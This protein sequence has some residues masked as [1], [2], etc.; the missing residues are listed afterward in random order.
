MNFLNQKPCI[1]SCVVLSKSMCISVLGLSSSPS[2]SLV[3]LFIHSGFSLCFLVAIFSSKIVRFL[4]HPVVGM[5][6]CHSFPVVGRIFFRCFGKSYFVCIVLPFV[7]ISLIF[8]L[9]PALSGLFTQVVLLFFS[10]V[11]CFCFLFPLISAPLFF[12]SFWFVFVVYFICISSGI[13]HPGFDCFFVLFEGIPIFSQ[14]N[15]AP[16]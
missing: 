7:D 16:A 6:S 3:I 14:T 2:S 1:P 4:W 5:F 9:W 15:F 12:L 13:F 8:L 11:A 10:C